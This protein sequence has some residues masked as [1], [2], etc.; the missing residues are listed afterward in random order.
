MLLRKVKLLYISSKLFLLGKSIQLLESKLSRTHMS[1]LSNR[2]TIRRARKTERMKAQFS[3]REEEFLRLL[4]DL[5][6]A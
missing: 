3:R 5:F 6:L 1:E 2:K 4:R